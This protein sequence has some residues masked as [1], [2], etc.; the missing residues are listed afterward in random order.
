VARQ[1]RRRHSELSGYSQHQTTCKEGLF[2]EGLF[3][4]L[5]PLDQ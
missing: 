5:S 4:A 2:E 1:A 3:D